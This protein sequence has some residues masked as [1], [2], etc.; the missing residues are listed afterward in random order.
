MVPIAIRYQPMPDEIKGKIPGVTGYD[1][2]KNRYLI[3]IDCELEEAKKRWT[4]KHELSHILL[5]HFSDDRTESSQAYL[6]NIQ[7][8][9]AEANEYA[10][11]MTDHELDCILSVIDDVKCLSGHY[12][13]E[14][15]FIPA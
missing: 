5:G 3:L 13:S 7:E 15:R 8:V 12:D 9:E 4:L 10:D 2:V 11:R 14:Y 1:P 6:K